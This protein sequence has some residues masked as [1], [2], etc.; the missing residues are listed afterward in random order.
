MNKTVDMNVKTPPKERLLIL[1]D[2]LGG[3]VDRGQIVDFLRLMRSNK[4]RDL[5]GFENVSRFD[6]FSRT[7]PGRVPAEPDDFIALLLKM[8]KQIRAVLAVT[9]DDQSFFHEAFGFTV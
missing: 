5:L 4:G 7:R 6:F 1:F 9:A 3:M 2:V 8:L